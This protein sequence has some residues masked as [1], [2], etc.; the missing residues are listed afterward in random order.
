MG[1]VGV[2]TGFVG[3]F[4]VETGL[5]GEVGEVGDL[6]GDFGVELPD[7]VGDFGVEPDWVLVPLPVVV[8]DCDKEVLVGEVD[9]P[10]DEEPWPADATC[11]FGKSTN[12][13]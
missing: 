11:E 8:F 5:V 4:G 9:E 13:S 12:M 6:V 1:D 7:L 10:D 2:E 3:D